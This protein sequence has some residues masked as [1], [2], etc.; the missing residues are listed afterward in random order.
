MAIDD[1]DPVSPNSPSS[2][3]WPRKCAF[4]VHRQYQRM[5]GSPTSIR[6][7]ATRWAQGSVHRLTGTA[8][9]SHLPPSSIRPGQVHSTPMGG[10]SRN[11]EE[12]LSSATNTKQ[13]RTPL[14]GLSKSGKLPVKIY[15][16]NISLDQKSS[17]IISKISMVQFKKLFNIPRTRKN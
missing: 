9:I 15:Y 16:F 2:K 17:N 12:S 8:T 6:W 10:I 11:W 13:T 7:Q 3:R 4:Q 14:R 5:N 1:P